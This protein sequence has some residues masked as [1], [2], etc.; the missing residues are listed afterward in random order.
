VDNQH[1]AADLEQIFRAEDVS[2][3]FKMLDGWRWASDVS[4]RP[5]WHSR[6][7]FFSG[8]V[9]KPHGDPIR[10]AMELSIEKCCGS[11]KRRRGGQI[12]YYTMFTKDFLTK[13]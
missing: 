4:E 7:R 13:S 8:P 10:T 2:D 11:V 6:L 5:R 12:K 3:I 1:L 9:Q